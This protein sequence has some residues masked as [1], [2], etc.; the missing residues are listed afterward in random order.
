MA[1]IKKYHG[2]ITNTLHFLKIIYKKHDVPSPYEKLGRTNLYEW[3]TDK[4]EIKTKYVH[5]VNIGT[6]VE[7]WKQILPMLENQPILRDSIVAMLQ[8]MRKASQPLA[9]STF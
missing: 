9:T 3:F 2:N 6:Q 5:V 7:T 8:K 4:G 1:A